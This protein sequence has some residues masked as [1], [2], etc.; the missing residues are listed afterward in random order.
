MPENT[1]EFLNE[2]QEELTKNSTPSLLNNLL[3]LADVLP[4]LA[5]EG[6]ALSTVQNKVYLKKVS[7]QKG[8]ILLCQKQSRD[9]FENDNR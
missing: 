1:P 3:I 4:D 5:K 2:K 7:S 8:A 9:Q 6:Y